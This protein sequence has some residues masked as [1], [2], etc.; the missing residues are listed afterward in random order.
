MPA[1]S[2]SRTVLEFRGADTVRFLNGQL[3]ND[4]RK[5]T[6][7]AALQACVMTAK[8]KMNGN[9]WLTRL[10]DRIRVDGPPE[11]GESLAARFERY[12]ISD[13]VTLTDVST[14]W[15]MEHRWGATAPSGAV[16][17]RRFGIDGFDVWLP[18][19]VASSPDLL[20]PD[21]A[22][23]FRIEQGIPLWGRELDENTIPVEA[24]LDCIDYH[25]GCYIGQEVISRLKSIGHV[26]RHLV[27][28][29][30]PLPSALTRG[31]ALEFG[32]QPVGIVTS[33]AASLALPN[34]VALA[35]LKRQHA[36]PGIVLT[37]IAAPGETYT[38]L[39]LHP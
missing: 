16:A 14:D 36:T 22:E 27:R 2:L 24:G 4:V 20:S 37:S 30:G 33:A 5:L 25:K 26:N 32:G 6:A 28:L 1:I 39:P 17:S 21:D 38:V 35:Y 12:I 8:G 15:K 10:P 23:A 9:V 19:D 11:I 3:S 13:D 31:L 7:A 34:T 18:A 29:L